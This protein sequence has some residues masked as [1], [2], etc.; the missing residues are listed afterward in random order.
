MHKDAP[1]YK[2]F[3][4]TSKKNQAK[5][6]EAQEVATIMGYQQAMAGTR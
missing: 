4:V 2:L 5:N 3:I 6:N 1:R